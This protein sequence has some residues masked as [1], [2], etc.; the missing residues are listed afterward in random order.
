MADRF[1]HALASPVLPEERYFIA[2][3]KERAHA[4]QRILAAMH[5]GAFR[6]PDAARAAKLEQLFALFVP[7]W[8]IDLQRT[9][10][11]LSVSQVHIGKVGIPIPR[12]S[13]T[14]SRATWM[15]CARSSFP[16]EMKNPKTL[17]AGD[18]KPLAVNLSALTP[19]DPDATGDWEVLDADVPQSQAR[20]A[21]G[22]SLRSMMRPAHEIATSTELTVYAAHFVRYPIWFARYRY[23]GL[24]TAVE[25][26]F[27]V[28]LSAVD[29][30]CITAHHPSKLRAGA[31]K[32]KGFFNAIGDKLSGESKAG[33][34]ASNDLR[35]RFKAH[36]KRERGK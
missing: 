27:H 35:E 23:S 13:S 9:D 34:P 32:V 21:G 4:E 7:F 30:T 18:A 36:V 29:D 6:P 15:V 5:D 33:D 11:S 2:P 24:A 16:Y 17:L 25:D 22:A 10:E 28:G 3:L 26:Q 14:D 8:R 31:A 19:G 1:A 20:H 12:T